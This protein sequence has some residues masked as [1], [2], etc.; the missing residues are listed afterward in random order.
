MQKTGQFSNLVGKTDLC[1]WLALPRSVY[2]YKPKSGKPG[3]KPSVHTTMSNGTIVANEL[4]VERIRIILSHEFV[5]YGYETVSKVLKGDGYIINKKKVYRLMDQ[6]NLL[7][8]KVIKT[9]GKREFVKHRKIEA[10]YPL[11]Y[12][13]L[14]IKYIWIPSESR[15]YYLLT[16]LDIYSRMSLAWIFQRNIRKMDVINLFRKIDKEH[17]IKGVTIRNDNGSQFIAN[18]VKQFLRIAEARQEFTHIAT[19]EENA[20]I[21]AFH[22]L[23]QREVIDRYEFADVT[24]AKLTIEAYMQFYNYQRLH[25]A[26]GFITPVQKWEQG[27]EFSPIRPPAAPVSEVWARSADTNENKTDLSA[28]PYNLDNPERT[29]YICLIGENSGNDDL[30]HNQFEKS[31]QFIGG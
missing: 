16:I 31:V 30:L 22:S 6:N 19:P 2:Y 25:R 14:D 9:N 13:C 15:H 3:I 20:Y 18:E 11:E 28:V 26:I 29:A 8:G 10:N 7:L 4:V 21:E 5:C 27:K 17:G 1:N 12:L 23:L 24:D